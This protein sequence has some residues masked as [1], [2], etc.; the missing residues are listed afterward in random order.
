MFDAF[1]VLEEAMTKQF[2][3][4]IFDLWSK[5][6]FMQEYTAPWAPEYI[7]QSPTWREPLDIDD[8]PNVNY[9]GACVIKAAAQG[10]ES[11]GGSETMRTIQ[12]FLAAGPTPVYCGWGSMVCKSSE[13][14]V[15]LASRALMH[16]GQRGIILSGYAKLSMTVLSKATDDAA[17][18]A[19]A[20]K[21]ILF[22]KSAPHEW[23]FPQVSCTVHHGGVGTLTAALRAG[24]PTIITPV[25]LDQWD[26]AHLVNRLGAG[27][28]FDKQL[29]KISAEELGDAMRKVVE[30]TEMA[31]KAK[32]A[33]EILQEEDGTQNIVNAVQDFWQEWVE[34]GKYQAK[35][36]DMKRVRSIS[37]SHYRR[38]PATA[39]FFKG[40]DNGR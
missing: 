13:H 20:E 29:Q 40:K 23:L 16:S 14:M 21:N 17:L 15:V 5:R 26:H 1:E 27:I 10:G 28:G 18:L 9:V 8:H 33:G 31:A 6:D 3:C 24:K 37:P 2:G 22:V 32:E 38:R 36:D 19:Y 25:F 34:S 7:C 4:K 39:D 30:S 35:M 11:F 12:A